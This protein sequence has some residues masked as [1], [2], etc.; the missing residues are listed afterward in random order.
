VKTLHR[1][2]VVL[3]GIIGL[4]A[5]SAL[6]VSA[7]GPAAAADTDVKIGTVAIN[8]MGQI[9]WGVSSGI[10][11]K[12][13]INVTEVRIFPAPPPTLAALAAGAVQIG[14]A[15][16]IAVINA[17]AN[18]GM[19]LKILAPA[20]GYRRSDLSTAKKDPALAAKLDDTGVCISPTSGI[21]SW[22][23]LSGK[24]VAVP[25]RKTQ[26]EVTIAQAVVKDGGNPGSINWVVLPFPT[27][28]DAVKSGKVNAAFTVEPFTSLCTSNGLKNLGS[29]GIQFFDIENAIGL[30]VTTADW[31]A[32]NP[33]GVLGFQ[34]SIKE[35]QTFGN[36][37]AGWDKLLQ[38]ANPTYT[39]V[40]LETARKANPSYFPPTVVKSDLR[41]PADKMLALG[42]LTKPLDINGLLLK[43]YRG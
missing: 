21:N 42:Y 20:D 36:T 28:I 40:D 2:G 35:I 18:S 15:P 33:Q 14:Y 3:G 16:S 23:D 34:K 29:P 12:N 32:K 25:A 41:G 10:F 30:W 1:T 7:A 38:S 19:A 26:G 43:Q 22:K 9:P 13:G 6:A 39:E 4:V 8:A 24:T 5:S 37:K 11:K 17:Y 31:A 27:M